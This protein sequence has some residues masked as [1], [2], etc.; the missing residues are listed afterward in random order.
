MTRILRPDLCVIGGGPGG[1]SAARAAAALGAKVVLVEKRIPV[2]PDHMRFAWWPQILAAAAGSRAQND[3][4]ETQAPPDFNQMRRD[5]DAAAGRFARE[6]SPARLSGLNI[7]LFQQAGSFTRPSRFEAGDTIIEAR[8]FLLAIA[9]L[10]AAPAIPGI[11][12]IRPLTPDRIAELASIPKR[13]AVLGAS[14]ENLQLIQSLQ[15]LGS[16]IILFQTGAFL[17][18]EDAELTTPLLD[19]LLR[20]G[21]EIADHSE[22]SRIEPAGADMSGT[23]MKIILADGTGFEASHL[24]YSTSRIP[25]TEGLGLKLAHVAYGKDGIKRTAGFQTSNPKIFVVNGGFD[26]FHAMTAARREGEWLAGR[27]FAKRPPAALQSAR[28]IAADPEIAVIGLSEAQA[29]ERRGAIRV[30]RAGFCDSPRAQ[31][32]QPKRHPVTG[33]VKIITDGHN[34]ILGAGIV[35]PQARELIGIFGLALANRLKSHDLGVLA[36]GEP[37][38]MDV[39]RVAALASAP[40]TGKV[41]SGRIFA[42]LGAALGVLRDRK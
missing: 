16:K 5:C 1:L 34:R 17:A 23:S 29:R 13:L 30:L 25:L 9:S 20:E 37:A 42:A 32:L 26:S 35:G 19:T 36:G 31:A 10:P 15:R 28:T 21:L 2:N 38:L 12:L 6:D 33:H 11:D 39:C 7:A 14:P 4:R 41:S 22:V 24:L 3:M 18:D 40:Q 27:L 8:H